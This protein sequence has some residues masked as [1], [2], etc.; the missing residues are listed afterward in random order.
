TVASAS[1]SPTP[2]PAC[3]T[4]S[5]P[6]VMPKGRCACG[7]TGCATAHSP[8]CRNVRSCLSN[9][10]PGMPDTRTVSA[11]DFNHRP[12]WVAAI[13]TAWR[14]TYFLGTKIR[15]DKDDLIRR[16]RKLTGLQSFGQDFWEEPLDRLLYA[17]AHEADLHPI[18]RFITRERLT[19]L[20]SIRLRAERDFRKD[21]SIL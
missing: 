2:I 8:S 13:N 14:G 6:A 5:T 3:P 4:G 1:S 11:S 20:L 17:I 21:P 16:A 19:H 7:G 15:L 18:G 9:N 10:F 12:A